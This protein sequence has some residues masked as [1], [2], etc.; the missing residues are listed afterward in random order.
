MGTGT[1]TIYS[2]SAGSGKTFKL[3]GIYLSRLFLSKYNY[4]KI[5]AV[6]FTNKATAEM[7]KR[8]LDQLYMLAKG[9]KSDYLNDLMNISGKNE[10]TIREEANEILFSILHDFSRFSVS[11]IDTFFQKVIRA[12]AREAGLQSGY[13]IELDHSLILS[14]AID[15]M[16][17]ASAEDTELQHWLTSYVMSN[18]EEEKTWN[19]KKGIMSLSEE[20]FRE[21]FRNLDENE[22]KKLEDK[23]F[24]REYIKKLKA[25]ISCFEHTYIDY[26][27]DCEKIF[28]DHELTEEMFF[29]KGRGV[30]G[31]IR[32]VAGGKISEPNQY[33][34]EVN[35]N[36]PRWS[37]KN[38]DPKLSEALSAGLEHKVKET[39]EFYNKNI[40]DYNTA[41][42]ILPHTYALG[43][44]TDVLLK[45]R[46]V[47]SDENSFLL[48]DSA[49]LLSKLTKE[50]QAPFIYEKIGNSFENFMIDEFQDTSYMQW[51]N[52]N[53]LINN[54]MG[55]GNDNLV[56]GD[57]KQ[58]IYRW[59][60]SDWK[61]LN[62]IKEE[63][64]D[65]KRFISIPLRTNWRSRSNIIRFNNSLF[66]LIPL[67]IDRSFAEDPE[68]LNFSKIYSEA[69]QS[70]PVK[71]NGGYVR[72]EF[73]G[74]D[75]EV[76]DRVNGK[77][78]QIIKT[79]VDKVLEKLPSVI[80]TI[81][82]RGFK[83][84]D[85]GILVRDR[86]E[87]AL[88]LRTMI[89]YGNRASLE[90][91]EKYNYNIVSNDSLTLANSH[92]VNFI[93]AVVQ[94]LNNPMDNIARAQMLR[95]YL[96]ANGVEN[97]ESVSLSSDINNDSFNFYLPE[98][99][100]TFLDK[101]R[102]LPLFEA[103][104]NIISFSGIGRVSCNVAYLN[105]LQ[106][107]ILNY[108][109]GKKAD[110]QSFLE[111]WENTGR[112]KSVV[113][114]ANQDAAPVFTIHKSKGL[115]FKV[116]ILPFLSWDLDHKP[117]KQ[118]VL[119]VK[120][121]KHPF[122]GPGIVPVRYTRDLEGTIFASDY[123]IEKY[124]SFLDNLNLLYV[125]M[126]RAKDA[127]YGYSPDTKGSTVGIASA[128]KEALTSDLNPA[129]DSGI[130]LSSMFDAE[131]KIFEFGDLPESIKK[132]DKKC[133]II[134]SDYPVSYK[135]G[136][137]RLKLHAE[138]YFSSDNDIAREKIRY[139][140]MMHEVFAGIDTSDD[141][142]AAVRKLVIE[143]KISDSD[144]YPLTV[145][146]KE[147]V[148]YP[149][150]SDW[151]K[152]GNKIMK[153]A[154]VLLPSGL[155]KRPDRVIITD[156]KAVIIDFKFGEENQHYYDQVKQ[157]SRL[158]KEMG[159][160][161]TSAFLWFVDRNKIMAV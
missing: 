107:W 65:H 75:V 14:K 85:I 100:G 8:I 57:I 114:P 46:Q 145:K 89:D 70:D 91:K 51:I 25:V 102:P 5:L 98:G 49:D 140:K 134:S 42:A 141:I 116:V 157:Y 108:S 88:I 50:D 4:R 58:S 151:F 106:D 44:L 110:F 62:T 20:L 86:R 103:V 52:F 133:E 59:R 47:T 41:K 67:Q 97:A 80:E 105:T 136:S 158:M 81:Q 64:T 2:A 35:S 126:T 10:E 94:V 68:A 54:S 104:E 90:Q 77:K 125:A 135:P 30:P 113:L 1:L 129:G 146:L 12:F 82:S 3:A 21:E 152:P 24:L 72:I 61:I 130:L 101:I 26:G 92:A 144:S 40:E 142:P 73:I 127:I 122:T 156:D 139:G 38:P 60:N 131:H 118:P 115:E 6:T 147:L 121:Q 120:P 84:S 56:V 66:S 160:I 11:T 95:S 13:S 15:E 111:W 123:K 45:V 53:P 161:D 29:Q 132:P 87:G 79:W 23:N 31:Y 96:F 28:L 138:N 76:P 148:S 17:V 33:V 18:L 78:P 74:N 128:M 124:S 71:E 39:I 7:K 112:F 16:I 9:E 69:V 83:A 43:I 117:P 63:W 99:F 143:G 109:L 93:I 48:S 55:E 137:L 27:K 32:N 155:V 34:R 159:Y 153:E 36:P 22:K 150:V 149:Q 37:S 119:W 154:A 19:L